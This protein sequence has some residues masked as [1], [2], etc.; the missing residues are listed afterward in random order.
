MKL[1][2]LLIGDR[3]RLCA[4]TADHKAMIDLDAAAQALH[5]AAEPIYASLLA[6]IEA[7]PAGL[8]KARALHETADDQRPE[9]AMLPL[10]GLCFAPPL[11][12]P[13]MLCFSVYDKHIKRAFEAA[14]T[15]RTG[16]G[17]GGLVKRLNLLKVPKRF[18]QRPLYYKGNHLSVSGHDQPVQ[19]PHY[20]KLMDYELE[21]GVVLWNRG[22]NIK[23]NDAASHI[24]GYTCF[25]DFSARDVLMQEIMRGVGPVKGKDFD[26]GNAMGPWVVTADEIPDPYDLKM[27]VRVNGEVRGRSSTSHMC[28]PIQRMIE[29]ASDEELI[30]P[31]TFFGTGAADHGCGIEDLRF[32]EPDDVVEIEL[33]RIGTL[34]NRVVKPS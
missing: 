8:D 28:H 33:E 2:S 26:T 18:Y 21:L 11:T 7:G 24:F 10:E 30:V 27:E 20:T 13:R 16:R 6:L 32:L 9:A 17:F 34:R 23:A 5:G 12:P 1:S 15:M 31:G 22:K 4:L 29:V 25:N 14:V 3:T 19:W